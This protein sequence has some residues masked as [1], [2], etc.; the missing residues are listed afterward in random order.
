MLAKHQTPSNVTTHSCK[1][2]YIPP[3]HKSHTS[4]HIPLPGMFTPPR[5]FQDSLQNIKKVENLPSSLI[6]RK[7]DADI[8]QRLFGS[9]NSGFRPRSR[10]D[11]TNNVNLASKCA[12]FEG[13]VAHRED[14]NSATR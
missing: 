4:D 2:I 10:T 12:G 11:A 1:S 13:F 5:T 6:D 9:A 7:N 8:L 3:I 14:Q